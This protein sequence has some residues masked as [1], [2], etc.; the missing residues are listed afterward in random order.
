[1]EYIVPFKSYPFNRSQKCS[2]DL[3]KLSFDCVRDI[4]FSSGTKWN[5]FGFT[6]NKKKVSKRKK[7]KQNENW[8]VSKRNKEKR[9]STVKKNTFC[10][11]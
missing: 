1:M 2:V 6:K 10:F 8:L 7:E 5:L 4:F 11:I 9:L 3:F